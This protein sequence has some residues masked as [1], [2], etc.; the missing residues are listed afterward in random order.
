MRRITATVL[1]AI[2]VMAV[3]PSAE[4]QT[5][6]DIIELSRAGLGEEVLLALIDVNGYVYTIDNAT[7]KQLKQ[8]GVSDRVIAEMVRKGRERLPVPEPQPPMDPPI[9]QSAPP[10]QVVVIEH[11]TQ[12]VREVLVP[13]YVAVAPVHRRF[14]RSDVTLTPSTTDRFIPFQ[15]GPPAV[16]PVVEEPKHPVYWGFGG[17]LRPDAWGQP[18][19]KASEAPNNRKQKD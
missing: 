10:P 7:L 6:K 19:D 16:R 15:S 13:V 3:A 1:V 14:R 8:A 2:A 18:A 9:E 11:H 17:K 5:A 4:A 12:E